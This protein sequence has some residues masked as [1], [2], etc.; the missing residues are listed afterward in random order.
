MN[1]L[2]KST[3]ISR[4]NLIDELKLIE[5]DMEDYQLENKLLYT[6]ASTDT[7]TENSTKMYL[8]EIGKYPLLTK[9]EEKE[10]AEKLKFPNKKKLLSFETKDGYNT[11]TLNTELL[12][13]SLCNNK[14]YSSIIE[15][16]LSYY[17]KTN[18][19]SNKL[20][21][22]KLKKYEQLSLNLNRPLTE[23]EL[24]LYFKINSDIKPLK[25]KELL[26]QTKEFIEY[27]SAFDKMFLSNLRLVV[28]IAKNYKC[29]IELLDLINEGNL[30]LMKAIE[31]YDSSLGF[32]F[33]TYAIWWIKQTI[34]RAIYMQGS[35]IRI[36]EN[37]QSELSKFKK[38]LE[39]LEFKE[40]RKLSKEEISKKLS[41][42]LYVVEDYF[43]AMF[44]IISLDLPVGDE[45]DATIMDLIETENNVEKEVFRKALKK[46]INSLFETL[47]DKELKVIKMRYGLGEYENSSTQINDIAK[48]MSVSQERIR[49]IERIALVKMRKASVMDNRSKSLKDYLN[50]NYTF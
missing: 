47:T 13:K 25:E 17:N 32:K 4:E 22:E 44:E 46:D 12:F 33:S 29:S 27:K 28:S 49:K 38:K 36:P 6:D 24:S 31:K 7:Y 14:S 43:K 5:S 21:I 39:Q 30:G 41:I 2:L 35:F 3:E 37:Y 26:K 10:I 42:P 45:K 9:E 1:E 23:E 18:N 48:E 11:S 50:E 19:N 8:N 34:K 20:V 40:K 15:T 16:L